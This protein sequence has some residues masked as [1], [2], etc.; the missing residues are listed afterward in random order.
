MSLR[1]FK[2]ENVVIEWWRLMH[3][4]CA[5]AVSFSFFFR[6][7]LFLLHRLQKNT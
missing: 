6:L 2:K 3:L 1:I 4:F 7:Q 5:S